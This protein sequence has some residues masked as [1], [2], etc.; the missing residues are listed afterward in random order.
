MSVWGDRR[1]D[2]LIATVLLYTPAE[3]IFAPDH[4]DQ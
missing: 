1:G 4:P 2:R 3:V